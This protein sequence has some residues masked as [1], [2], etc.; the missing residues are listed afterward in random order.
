MG[1]FSPVILFVFLSAIFLKSSTSKSV[2]L[3]AVTAL[4]AGVGLKL[5][6]AS[7]EESLIEP[8][9]H[10]MAI[11]FVLAF[12]VNAIFSPKS[13]NKKVFVL[14]RSDFRTSKLFN[15][16]STLIVSV[17]VGIYIYFDGSF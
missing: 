12:L 9:M 5:Y 14:D 11:S 2:L 17:I 4:I 15:F 10:Q 8:F 3:G 1:L 13:E 16:G 6:V 7:T